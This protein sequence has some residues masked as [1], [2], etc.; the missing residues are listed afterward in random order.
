MNLKQIDKAIFWHEHVRD[1][2]R[3]PKQKQRCNDRILGLLQQRM[4][5][6]RAMAEKQEAQGM[7]EHAAWYDTSAELT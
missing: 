3:D 6:T 1:Q 5:I 7:R 4:E 2:S